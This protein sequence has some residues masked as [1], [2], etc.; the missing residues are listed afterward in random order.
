MKFHKSLFKLSPSQLSFRISRNAVAHSDHGPASRKS[1]RL[2]GPEKPSV[3]L[4]PP[5]SVKL[6]F[7]YVVKGIKIKIT[8]RFHVTELLRFEDTKRIM[9]PEKFRDFREMGPIFPFGGAL[10]HIPKDSCE[11][12]YQVPGIERLLGQLGRALLAVA[13][14]ER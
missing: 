6:I 11:G 1:R 10:R 14:V 5:R 13:L 7:S 12:D 4:R 8:A 3:K 2:F 9:S